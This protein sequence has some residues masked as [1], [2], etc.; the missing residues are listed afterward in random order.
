MTVKPA[1]T[2]A[3]MRDLES[4]A[5]TRGDTT[6]FALMDRAGRGVVDAAFAAWPNLRDTPGTAVV[7]CGPGN[8]GGDGYVIATALAALGWD[9]T[10]GAMGTPTGD[11]AQARAGWHGPV[12]PLDALP[13]TPVDLVVEALFGIG[14][15]R[16]L[17]PDLLH[18]TRAQ[19][20]RAR[21]SLAVDVPAGFDADRGRFLA[22]KGDDPDDWALTPDLVVTFEALKTGHLLYPFRRAPI[23]V[24]LGLDAA[25]DPTRTLWPIAP[26]DPG[27]WF[28]DITR[29]GTATHKFARGHVIVL[30]GPAGRTGAARL[31]ARAALRAGAGLV[32]IASPPDA[33]A[34]HAAR[35]D[36]IMLHPVADAAA[37][38]A[39]L[40]DPRISAVVAG[41]A[42]G[43]DDT[44]LA[45]LQ[46]V[47]ASG[48]KLVLDADAL[49]LLSRHPQPLPEN[50]ILTPHDGEFARLFPDLADGPLPRPDATRAAA[51]RFGVPILRKGPATLI[52]TPQARVAVHSAFRD[53]AVP[54]L[55]T[56]GAGDVLAGFIAGL[57]TRAPLAQAAELAAWLHVETARVFGPGLIAEDL[58]N[59]L[60]RVLRH[61]TGHT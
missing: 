15:S 25:D 57:A 49:T 16:P 58:P 10:V 11:A 32:T 39:F 59:T 40:N 8:N 19:L 27:A 37:L 26:D 29:S 34:E 4:A 48:H 47:L 45:L 18:L 21:H 43:L 6:G 53:R 24:P 30:S 23:V 28:A 46:S 60:P 42:L 14:L 2:P 56:A 3:F 55:A 5:I 9:V 1:I 36:A 44:A 61:I 13:A 51:Q 20:A 38:R 12:L 22:P 17:S 7:L 33:M 50:C 41:P 54:Q 52:A 31:A 35:L